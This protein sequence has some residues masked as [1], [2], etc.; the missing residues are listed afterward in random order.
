MINESKDK[1]LQGCKAQS[2]SLLAVEEEGN[3]EKS[4][5]LSEYEAVREPFERAVKYRLDLAR[6]G[7]FLITPCEDTC[8]YCAFADICRKDHVPSL[9]RAALSAQAVK[10]RSFNAP[11]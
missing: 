11:K 1:N 2:A 4:F 9:R 3:P 6:E 10:L 5:S 7:V 8:K